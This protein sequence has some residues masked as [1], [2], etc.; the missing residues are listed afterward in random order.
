MRSLALILFQ[1]LFFA[2]AA[3]LLAGWVKKVKAWLQNRRGMPLLQGYR[4]LYK[5][6]AKQA[7][8]ADTASMVFRIAPYVVFAA[9]LLA[10]AAIP[11]IT[12]RLPTAAM[13][14]IIVVVG[15]LAL[16]RFFLALAGMDVGTAFGGMG[17]PAKC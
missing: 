16:G 14:D 7:V 10:A 3:P 11:V 2:L 1:L 5:L 12:S 17:S 4:T 6:A 9:T 13:A 8:V 15:L